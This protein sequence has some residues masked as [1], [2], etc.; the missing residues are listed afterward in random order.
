MALTFALYQW[1]KYFDLQD[2]YIAFPLQTHLDLAGLQL[3]D[4]SV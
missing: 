3:P 4:L 2:C 1:L